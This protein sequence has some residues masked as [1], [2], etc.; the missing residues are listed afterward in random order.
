MMIITLFSVVMKL[1]IKQNKQHQ[2]IDGSHCFLCN[3]P[4]RL[5]EI[6]SE[7]RNKRNG[8][9]NLVDNRNGN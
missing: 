9:K 5:T 3:S 1:N 2:I 7:F 8:N 6:G 4:S